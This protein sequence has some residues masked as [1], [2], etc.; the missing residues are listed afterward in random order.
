MDTLWGKA[1]K[2][3]WSYLEEDRGLSEDTIIQA[4]LG[5]IPGGYQE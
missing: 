1:G 2:R 3:A 4:G 5:Y